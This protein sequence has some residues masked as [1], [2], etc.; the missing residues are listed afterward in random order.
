MLSQITIT[1]C[2]T[3][4]T[5]TSAFRSTCGLIIIIWTVNVL[6]QIGAQR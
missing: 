5:L 2:I 1:T 4:V 6:R 3:A